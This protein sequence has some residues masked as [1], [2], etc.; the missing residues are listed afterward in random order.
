MHVH[1]QNTTQIS[2]GKIQI[3][4]INSLKVMNGY[5]WDRDVRNDK[6]AC[7]FKTISF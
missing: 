4:I 3:E 6:Y 5:S 7:D 2:L 1:S